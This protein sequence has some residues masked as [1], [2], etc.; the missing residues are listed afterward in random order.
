MISSRTAGLFFGSV[1]WNRAHKYSPSALDNFA[2]NESCVSHKTVGICSIR[3]FSLK[4]CSS[5]YLGYI[6]G[7]YAAQCRA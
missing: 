2:E 1:L 4:R 5:Y 6:V 7:V 3:R